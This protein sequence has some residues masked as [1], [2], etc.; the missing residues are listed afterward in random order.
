MKNP[1]LSRINGVRLKN[2]EKSK[3]YE[4]FKFF[5]SVFFSKLKFQCI[6]TFPRLPTKQ[7]SSRKWENIKAHKAS[8]MYGKLFIFPLLLSEHWNVLC[9]QP[10]PQVHE[11]ICWTA[12]YQLIDLFTDWSRKT[13][14]LRFRMFFFRNVCALHKF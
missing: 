5:F 8:Q 4:T 1:N 12:T 3:L 6:A 9:I 14:P 10:N 7:N 13:F 2:N 11:N